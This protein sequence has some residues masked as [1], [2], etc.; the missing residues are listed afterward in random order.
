MAK[1]R[2]RALAGLAA[3]VLAVS[4]AACGGSGGSS[5]N[6]G[7]SGGG[8]TPKKGGTITVLDVSEFEGMDPASVYLGLEI[9]DMRR[10]AYRGL[11]AYP[12]SKDQKVSGTPVA[13]LATDTGTPSNGGKDWTFTIKSG[14]KWQ[15]GT[16]ITP[17]DFAYGLSRSFDSSLVN[18]TGVGTTYLSAYNIGGLFKADGSSDYPGPLTA[19]PAQQK[20]FDSKAYTID[21]NK[22]TYHFQNPWPD[23]PLQAASLF[24]FDPYEKSKEQGTKGLWTVNSDGPYMLQGGTFDQAK[25]G[26]FVRNPNYDPSTDSKSVR[27]AYPDQIKYELLGTL[28]AVFDRLVA[29]GGSDQT[30]YSPENIDTPHYSQIT[31]AVAS[32]AVASTSPYTRFLE[33]NELSV[34]DPKVRRALQLATD[35]N[36]ILAALGGAHYGTPTST[37]ISSGVPGYV[38]NPSTK[39]DKASGDPEAAKAMLQQAGVPMPYPI[40]Y[41]FSDS[42]SQAEK[43]AAVYKSSWEKAGFKVTLD[44]IAPDAKPSYYGQVSAKDKKIDVFNAGWGADWPALSTV[45]PPILKSNPPK[46]TA[47]VGFNYGFYSNKQVDDLIAQSQQAS[48]VDAANKLLQQADAIAAA[49]GA[50]VPLI[51]QKNWLLAGSKIGGFLPD[52]AANFYP[53]LGG[54]YVK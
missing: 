14:V 6:S 30:A 31:G 47:G 22:I 23:F 24:T 17:Q 34:K 19:T 40:T 36:S 9:A 20:E 51:Q 13:D 25:G 4:L 8:S 5:N 7:G 2:S 54:M 49:D 45:I 35:K 16:P 44:P 46:A 37:I 33:I 39:D 28:Q 48:S 18:G 15:D 43:V 3:S 53:D 32:R 21:G 52:V 42:G 10:L 38:E 26:T 11:V 1:I 41:A 12:I 50:Y 27:G 29:D